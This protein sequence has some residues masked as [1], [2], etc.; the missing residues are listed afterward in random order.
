MKTMYKTVVLFV[1]I[2]LSIATQAAEMP[3]WLIHRPQSAAKGVVLSMTDDMVSEWVQNNYA[4]VVLSNKGTKFSLDEVRSAMEYLRDNQSELELGNGPIGSFAQAADGQVILPLITPTS[5]TKSCPDFVI[6]DQ[7][8][9]FFEST[10]SYS[11]TPPCIVLTDQD[12]T[13]VDNVIVFYQAM[14]ANNRI[15]ELILTPSESVSQLAIK[16]FMEQYAQ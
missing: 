14:T 15:C 16:R 7:P 13:M 4:V 9:F 3:Q 12:A 11:N 8:E 10:L 5:P 1:A 6:L 2:V